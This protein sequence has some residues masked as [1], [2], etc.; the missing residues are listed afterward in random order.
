MT[1]EEAEEEYN[2]Q[3]DIEIRKHLESHKLPQQLVEEIAR[4]YLN[5]AYIRE[6]IR[7]VYPGYLKDISTHFNP[8]I[9]TMAG[10]YVF[11]S[12]SLISQGIQDIY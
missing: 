10:M 9:V 7:E 5:I 12:E 3:L 4:K 2:E 11:M 8:R 1:R 6:R